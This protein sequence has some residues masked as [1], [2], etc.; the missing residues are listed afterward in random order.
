MLQNVHHSTIAEEQEQENVNASTPSKE[1][2]SVPQ[3][4]EGDE[5]QGVAT[6]CI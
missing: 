1:L 5:R 4:N 6:L 2:A 3:A